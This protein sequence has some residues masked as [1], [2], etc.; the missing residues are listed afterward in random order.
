M[1][2]N[3]K[4]YESPK[5]PLKSYIEHF[6][7]K[8]KVLTSCDLA[9]LISG[10]SDLRFK[11]LRSAISVNLNRLKK[12]GKISKIATKQWQWCVSEK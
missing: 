2:K 7:L 3:I 12:E 9:L 11:N 6:F 5:I 8:Y 4:T 10:K 1:T